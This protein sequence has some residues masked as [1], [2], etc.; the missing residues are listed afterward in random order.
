[1][2]PLISATNKNT[3][4]TIKAQI[5]FAKR[6]YLSFTMG[7]EISVDSE[8]SVAKVFKIFV[9]IILFPLFLAKPFLDC[10]LKIDA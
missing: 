9:L 4:T 10:Q 7:P 6:L 8:P 3:F 5:G 1:M 2:R